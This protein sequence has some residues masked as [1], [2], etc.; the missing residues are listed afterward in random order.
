MLNLWRSLGTTPGLLNSTVFLLGKHCFYGRHSLIHVDSRLSGTQT[1][2]S[3]YVS[4]LQ[5][6]RRLHRDGIKLFTGSCLRTVGRLLEFQ[7]PVFMAK[8][9][10][11]TNSILLEAIEVEFQSF[12][13]SHWIIHSFEWNQW[14]QID[15]ERWKMCV[16]EKSLLVNTGINYSRLHLRRTRQRTTVHQWAGNK[17]SACHIHSP[18]TQAK[19]N[20]LWTSPAWAQTNHQAYAMSSTYTRSVRKEEHV[21]ARIGV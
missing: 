7:R 20:P 21:R 15:V 5:G 6:W 12:W 18:L 16:R 8:C 14:N 3:L 11:S 17:L 4:P 10:S 2:F 19:T 9:P 1:E 13:K